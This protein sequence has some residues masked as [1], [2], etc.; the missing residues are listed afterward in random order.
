MKCK[1][2]GCEKMIKLRSI[3][4]K[5]IQ[6]FYKIDISKYFRND[7]F[8]QYMCTNCQIKSFDGV[9]PADS[10]FYDY[11]QELPMYYESDKYEFKKA[12]ECILKYKPKKIL[13]IGAGRGYFLEKIKDSFEVRA[14]EYSEKSLKY[15]KSKGIQLDKDD[16][17]Y[18]F[19]VS[20]Q[21]LEHVDNLADLLNFIDKKLETNGYLFISVPNNDSLYFQETFDILDYPPHHMHQFNEHSLKYIA[22]ILNYKLLEYWTEP[23]RIEHFGFIIRHRRKKIMHRFKFISKFLSVLDYLFLPYMYDKNI[24]GHTHMVLLQ[25]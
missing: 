12:I 16:D 25:K 6:S 8:I 20:F 23:I 21:V 4:V 18:D 17:T 2:C 3:D 13:E 7:Q 24:P 22:K 5:Y 19:I 10:A 15:L 1:L 9:I 11:I 14:T